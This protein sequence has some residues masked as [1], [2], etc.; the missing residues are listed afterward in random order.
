MSSCSDSV[1]SDG[2]L[3]PGESF[4]DVIHSRIV[5]STRAVFG[6]IL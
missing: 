4:P 3:S 5:L 6:P 1:R 2:N